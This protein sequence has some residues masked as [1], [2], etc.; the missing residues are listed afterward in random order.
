MI[1]TLMAERGIPELTDEQKAEL[2][3]EDAST[4]I[5]ELIN[6]PRETT[7]KYKDVPAGRYALKTAMGSY[8]DEGKKVDYVWTFYKVDAPKEGEWAGRVFLSRMM[9]DDL[10]PVRGTMYRDIM[11]RIMVDPQQAMLDY[12]KQIEHCGHCGKLLT[13][14]ESRARGIGPKC[15]MKMG[16]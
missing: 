14:D 11:D 10:M 13:N 7:S 5:D 6:M 1:E 8:D 2:S 12:G 15:A 3:R 16:W 9:S 4:K